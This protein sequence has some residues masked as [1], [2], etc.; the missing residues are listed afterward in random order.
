MQDDVARQPAVVPKVA[1]RVRGRRGLVEAV[2]GNDE[3]L[4]RLGG[5]RRHLASVGQTE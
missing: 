4:A 5:G 2:V 3:Q 1:A